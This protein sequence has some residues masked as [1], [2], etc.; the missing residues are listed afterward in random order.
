MELLKVAR[1]R[2][3]ERKWARGDVFLMAVFP[4]WPVSHLRH[5]RPGEGRAL[6]L[7]SERIKQ[8][9]CRQR[10]VAGLKT[11]PETYILNTVRVNVIGRLSPLLLA[12]RRIS[13]MVDTW[14]SSACRFQVTFK[15]LQ[16]FSGNVHPV[17]FSLN[18]ASVL[19]VSDV[20][21]WLY[22]FQVIKDKN[23]APN[24]FEP[25]TSD[26]FGGFVIR[27]NIIVQC[28]SKT[29]PLCSGAI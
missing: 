19:P 12:V 22:W 27:Q 15:V 9:E 13:S 23:R 5:L 20:G 11:W 6:R 1:S 25:E 17:L 16:R 10:L 4:K 28:L 24:L 8:G 29:I 2:K 26:M 3:R 21:V 18:V 14:P 7:C